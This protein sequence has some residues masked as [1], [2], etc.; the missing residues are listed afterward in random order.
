[1]TLSPV[2]GC[3]IAVPYGKRVRQR[4]KRHDSLAQNVGLPQPFGDR[5]H[6]TPSDLVAN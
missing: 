2:T 4:V 3:F 6:S 1:V 5:A